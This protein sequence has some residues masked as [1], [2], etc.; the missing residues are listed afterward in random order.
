MNRKKSKYG[1]LDCKDA[2]WFLVFPLDRQGARIFSH[3][4]PLSHTIYPQNLVQRQALGAKQ[5]VCLM[6]AINNLRWLH[7]VRVFA[8]ILFSETRAHMKVNADKHD[9]YTLSI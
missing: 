8:S 2:M 6:L 3:F 1:L 4:T 9:S 7:Y 5:V